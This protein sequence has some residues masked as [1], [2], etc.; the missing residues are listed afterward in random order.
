[1]LK[2]KSLQAG[3]SQKKRMTQACVSKVLRKMK[4][5]W[6]IQRCDYVFVDIAKHIIRCLSEKYLKP[7]PDNQTR[8]LSK[9]VVGILLLFDILIKLSQKDWIFSKVSKRSIFAQNHIFSGCVCAFQAD[10]NIQPDL[11]QRALCGKTKPS[12]PV[13]F[14]RW[15]HT[16]SW[17]QEFRTDS[18]ASEI[19][20]MTLCG[21]QIGKK[22][23]ECGF[24]LN[25]NKNCF[26]ECW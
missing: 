21:S 15:K 24:I 16:N 3:K 11:V 26:Q 12:Y 1:M 17:Q 22:I 13:L 7:V 8:T 25:R 4:D 19:L 6:F 5:A 9:K 14:K 10:N 18:E 23:L 20:F 2:Q